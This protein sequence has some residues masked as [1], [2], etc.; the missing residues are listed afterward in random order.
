MNAQQLVKDFQNLL[1]KMIPEVIVELVE[2]GFLTEELSKEQL[3]KA[4]K[5][6]VVFHGR[7]QLFDVKEDIEDKELDKTV[8]HIFLNQEEFKKYLKNK[9]VF[10]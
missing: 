3:E 8:E 7:M 2:E 6:A 5:N 4:V 10:A 9:I 1:L